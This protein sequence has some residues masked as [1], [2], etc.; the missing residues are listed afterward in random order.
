[1]VCLRAP[2][3]GRP[4]GVSKHGGVGKARIGDRPLQLHVAAATRIILRYEVECLV[5]EGD[6]L[7]FCASPSGPL[8]CHEQVVNGSV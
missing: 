6:G 7:R 2:N 8:G 1:V 5:V 4:L 3:L